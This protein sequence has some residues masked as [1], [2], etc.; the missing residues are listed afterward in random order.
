VSSGLCN[1]SGAPRTRPVSRA[2]SQGS[3]RWR[4]PRARCRPSPQWSCST[5]AAELATECNGAAG[6]ELWSFLREGRPPGTGISG[7]MARQGPGKP[8]LRRS[9]ASWRPPGTPGNRGMVKAS[10]AARQWTARPG[11][12]R[13]SDNPTIC[14]RADRVPE[15]SGEA[16]LQVQVRRDWPAG[17]GTA[18]LSAHGENGPKCQPGA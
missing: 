9:R 4:A 8:E 13:K 11:E 1:F 18:E 15:P 12:G 17:S 2:T 6:D 10:R 5:A 7:L 14:N 16:H 3:S